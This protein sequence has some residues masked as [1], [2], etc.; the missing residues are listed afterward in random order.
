MNARMGPEDVQYTYNTS[1]NNNGSRLIEMMEEYQLIAANSQ[2]RKKRGKLWTWMSPHMTKHQLDY[3]LVRK[4]W[5]KSLRNC[6][7]YYTF[8]NLGSDHIIVVANLTLSLRTSKQIENRKPKYVWSDIRDQDKLQD[9]HAVEVRNKFNIQGLDEET[10]S[11][12][13][14]WLVEVINETAVGCMSQDPKLKMKLNYQDPRI[15]N[16]REDIN[17]V[18]KELVNKKCQNN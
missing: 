17:S 18:H 6:E 14:K 3:I 2:F 13:Y 9:R 11:E 1:T 5:R 4:K 8:I 16:S 15:I 12:R 7:P 10:I